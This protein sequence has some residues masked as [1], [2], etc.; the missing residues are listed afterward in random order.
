M[1]DGR[2]FANAAS[3]AIWAYGFSQFS[4]RACR[5][6]AR[7]F[8]VAATIL[9]L[10]CSPP[11]MRC[12]TV[13][14]WEQAGMPQPYG[15]IEAA[16][17]AVL[18]ELQNSVKK[19]VKLASIERAHESGLDGATCYLEYWQTV[20]GF[21]Q[22]VVRRVPVI[23]VEVC[24]GP[25]KPSGFCSPARPSNIVTITI[26]GTVAF[27]TD[28]ARIF[29]NSTGNLAGKPFTLTYSFDDAKGAMQVVTCNGPSSCDSRSASIQQKSS[30]GTAVLR[31]GDGPP[32]SFGSAAGASSS[33]TKLTYPCCVLGRTYLMLFNVEDSEG[34]VAVGVSN[35][36]EGTPA[37]TD[38]DWRAPFFDA[39]LARIVPDP[40][41]ENDAELGFSVQ[42]NGRLLSSGALIPE[43]ICVSSKGSACP[44]N[45]SSTATVPR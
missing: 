14:R 4:L 7:R 24:S 25:L 38:G 30:P 3:A 34:G 35:T 22:P 44:E 9:A 10:L 6:R 40:S 16:C 31:I 1:M 36:T 8:A 13:Q 28:G 27:G 23:F 26:T 45:K 2:P 37:T 41:N 15:S 17:D 11:A 33:A 43:T 18:Q 39:Q 21:V 12:Q 32:H 19:P 20:P 5:N 42:K 29:G